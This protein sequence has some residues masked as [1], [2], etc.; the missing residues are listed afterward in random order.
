MREVSGANDGVGGPDASR[1]P[2]DAERQTSPLK[3]I[4]KEE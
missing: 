4:L 2:A 3:I 1:S